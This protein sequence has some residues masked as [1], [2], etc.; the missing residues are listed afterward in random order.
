M[1]LTGGE[2]VMAGALTSIVAGGL[3]AVIGRKGKVSNSSCKER[4]EAITKPL[5]IELKYI[6]EAVD[7]IKKK[8]NGG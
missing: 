2:I 8:V 1:M 7:E 5:L 6:K 3:G 4:Q